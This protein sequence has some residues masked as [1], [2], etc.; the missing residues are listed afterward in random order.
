MGFPTRLTSILTGAT[1]SQLDHWR[2]TG[3]V[4]PEVHAK[5]PPLYSFRDLI[6]IRSVVFL[7]ANTS[8][9]R[10]HRAFNNI[11]NVMDAVEHPS[12]YRFGV[13]DQTIFLGTE[14]GE[15]IDIL[16]RVGQPTIFTF[17]DMLRAFENFKGSPVPD[18]E[19]PGDHIEVRPAR[20]GGWP[21]VAGTRV[22]YDDIARLVDFDSVFPEDVEYFYPSV[23]ADAAAGA[24]AFSRQVEAVAA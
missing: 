24:V 22:A 21:T 23:S 20:L 3:L 10:I 15:A 5:R 8:S 13:D 6:L 4:I 12:R 19:R 9:Q 1:P 17:A 7:R 11:P 2:E 18:F 16:R 14:D